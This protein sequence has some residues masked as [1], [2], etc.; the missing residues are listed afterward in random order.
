MKYRKTIMAAL[1]MGGILSCT[2]AAPEGKKP[3]DN[4]GDNG[5]DNNSGPVEHP[6]VI[7]IITDQQYADKLGC[8]G[9]QGVSTPALDRLANAGIA[10][11]N[12]YC[13]FPLSVPSRTSM[14]TGVQPSTIGVRGN[15]PGNV[16]MRGVQP[17][18][19]GKLFGNAGYDTYYGGKI[20]LPYDDNNQSA[21]FYGFKK[22]YT[23]EK[24]ANLGVSA[25]ALL[26]SLADSKKPF[27]MVVSFINPHDICGFDKTNRSKRSA[28]LNRFLDQAA[29]YTEAEKERVFPPLRPNFEAAVDVPERAARSFPTFTIA[30]WRLRR[31]AYDR[32]VEEADSDI[33]PVVDVIFDKNMLANS[34]VIFL[35]DHGD[36]DSAHS[37]ALKSYPF[38]E[39]QNVPLIIAGKGVKKGVDS[40]NFV[41]T[42]IDLIPTLCDFANITVPR[43]MPGVSAKPLATGDKNNLSRQHIFCEGPNWYQVIYQCRYKFTIFE[44][45]GNPVML[46]DLVSD[47]LELNDLK[48]NAEKAPILNAANAVLR[49]D[50]AARGITLKQS[51]SSEDDD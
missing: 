47:P 1:A 45:P 32:L 6:N 27:L 31:W 42:G 11:R 24:R 18:L 46:Y 14:F 29:S 20:H 28:V 9:D 44:A 41:Q 3:G 38:N 35:S 23:T 17:Q 21:S 4:G 30:Q 33:K 49:A 34:V 39:C 13:A 19:M 8:M 26:S 37:M 48:N 22:T 40:Y 10:F 16:D 15:A 36:M 12:A 25:A 50:L 2:K 7:L 43:G 51:G 5:G